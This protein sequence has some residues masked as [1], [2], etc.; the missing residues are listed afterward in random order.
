MSKFYI[1]DYKLRVEQLN[2]KY[3]PDGDGQHPGY[4]RRDWRSL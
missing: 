3:N 1:E 4:T 2:D